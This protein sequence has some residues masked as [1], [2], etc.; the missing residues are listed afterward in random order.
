MKVTL[1]EK[2]II[3][4]VSEWLKKRGINIELENISL[5]A[6]NQAR[7]TISSLDTGA[8]FY[9]V[10]IDVDIPVSQGPYR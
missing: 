9:A 7:I 4:A 6:K 5:I 8:D 1:E 3:E 2:E 10:I